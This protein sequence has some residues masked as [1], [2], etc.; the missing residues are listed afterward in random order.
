MFL[1]LY[2]NTV[3]K[4]NRKSR[5]ERQMRKIV[6]ALVVSS[7][8]LAS[9][10]FAAET[11]DLGSVDKTKAPAATETQKINVD[12]KGEALNL[13]NTAVADQITKMKANGP[14]WMK[15]TDISVQFQ[16]NFK[17]TYSIET[18]QLIGT[19]TDRI[20]TFTQ[21]RVG[22]DLGEGVTANLG[23]GQRT[24]AED[25]KSMF[26]ENVFYDHAFKYGHARVGAGLEYFEGRNEYRANMYH[27]ISGKKEVDATNHI[28]EKALSGYDAEIG[29]SLPNAPWAKVFIQGYAWD[30]TYTNDLKGYKLR[31]EIQVT[32][33]F[34]LEFGYKHETGNVDAASGKYV[35]FMYTLGASGKA[36]MF[37]DGKEIFR[38]DETVTVEGKR[39]DKVKRENKIE[40][41]RWAEVT[42]TQGNLLHVAVKRQ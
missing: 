29:T 42:N 6:P 33:Q 24:L 10:V 38:S 14:D 21:F 4:L 3:T 16:Q 11:I 26:G 30:Y 5:G 8:L 40:V 32:P 28:F 9:P 41:E 19:Q 1:V 12:I 20:T 34:N 39:F 2:N 17:P 7:M 15:R 35:K 37:E 25:K 31:S 18:L 27:A 23:F 22:N 36:A 13:T